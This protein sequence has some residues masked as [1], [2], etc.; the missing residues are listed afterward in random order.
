MKKGD[1]IGGYLILKDFIVAG[2]MSKISFAT[3][4]ETEYFIKEF[5]SPKYP[6]AGCPGSPEMI[7][8]K[9]KKCDDFEKHHK[10]LNDA[11]GSKCSFGG[12]LV[13]AV[14]F[15]R[16]GTSYYKITEKIDIASL[17]TKDIS[18]L[19]LDKVLIILKTVT[20]SLKILHDLN[21]VHGDLKPDN[22]LIK[23]TTTGG[24]TTKLIDFDN[25]YFSG[26]PPINKEEVVGTPE[27][28]SPELAFYIK[29]GE[30]VD[31]KK[32]TTQSDIFA[33]G[34]IFCEYLTGKKPIFDKKN[35]YTWEAINNKSTISFP[36]DCRTPKLKELISSMLHKEDT[37]R[38][39]ISEVFN[40]LK[41]SDIAI[42][43]TTKSTIDEVPIK[44][45]G[46][47]IG[48]NLKTSDSG[49]DKKEET[50]KKGLIIKGLKTD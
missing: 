40:A 28:Y 11:I 20:H 34:V 4:G 35:N 49:T 39:K 7:A 31:R 26:E 19:S 44:T 50:P 42:G 32:L 23:Q 9:Q 3:N 14:D 24:Y 47:K 27:Y 2:G 29:N 25:S 10:K 36:L 46:L 16:D 5:L 18:K 21:I 30:E 6:V 33:L 8:K 48:K 38:P 17:S 41:G 37:Q 15:F 13:F 43:E 45:G 12:N 1:V 22:I